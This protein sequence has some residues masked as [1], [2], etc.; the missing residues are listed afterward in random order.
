MPHERR[1]DRRPEARDDGDR[2]AGDLGVVR[3]QDIQQGPL[4]TG[5][6][7]PHAGQYLARGEALGS[8]FGEKHLD[9]GPAA[10]GTAPVVQSSSP[11]TL[12]RASRAT[13]AAAT[14]TALSGSAI[15]LY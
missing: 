13:S 6:Q 5:R 1:D 8:I 14:R 11:R 10:G 12:S 7:G 9:R 4:R 15:A 2:L 3:S